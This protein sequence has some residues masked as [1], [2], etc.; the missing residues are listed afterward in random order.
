MV[1]YRDTPAYAA[2]ARNFISLGP[3]QVNR[4]G[5][6]QYFV[7]LG[8]WNTN[9]RADQAAGRDGF[10]SIVLFVDGEPMLLNVDGWTP[11]TIGAS[12]PVYLQPVASAIDAYYPVTLDQIRLIAEAN[13]IS[14]QTTG[15]ASR[16]FE[17]WDKQS[18]ALQA[19]RD[20]V[21]ATY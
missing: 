9:Q 8:I 1:L 20:F 13:S 17:L 6:Y 19:F 4:S 12:E 15:F 2:N 10:D 7:W 21:Q 5:S 3:L 18:Q 11:D 16:T 14:L